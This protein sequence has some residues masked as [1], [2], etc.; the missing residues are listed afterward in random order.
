MGLPAGSCFLAPQT[1]QCLQAVAQATIVITLTKSEGL[2]PWA[3][4]RARL[5]EIS[6][7][8]QFGRCRSQSNNSQLTCRGY[9]L[10]S[11]LVSKQSGQVLKELKEPPRATSMSERP[12]TD[13][14]PLGLRMGPSMAKRRTIGANLDPYPRYPP[15][16]PAPYPF[17][18]NDMKRSIQ[19]DVP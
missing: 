5:S 19:L 6:V 14:Q 17:E 13:S 9:L 8:E 11:A 1:I 12:L 7:E 15:L 18:A 3:H 16:H 2:A 4:G 10:A